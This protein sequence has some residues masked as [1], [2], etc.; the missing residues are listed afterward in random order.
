MDPPGAR[1]SPRGFQLP[2]RTQP[3]CNSCPLPCPWD[4]NFGMRHWWTGFVPEDELAHLGV[5]PVTSAELSDSERGSLCDSHPINS[6]RPSGDISICSP[7]AAGRS[8]SWATSLWKLVNSILQLH[9]E[10]TPPDAKRQLE[11]QKSCTP[12][13]SQNQPAPRW[14]TQTQDTA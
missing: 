2:K 9:T 12:P 10:P 6:P 5:D 8:S 13:W 7:L 11:P 4:M 1:L 14:E 3:L